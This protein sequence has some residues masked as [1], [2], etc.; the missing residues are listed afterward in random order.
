MARLTALF[1]MDGKAASSLKYLPE[2]S[3]L[4]PGYVKSWESLRSKT[5]LTLPP[6]T[7]MLRVPFPQC[8]KR[9]LMLRGFQGQLKWSQG[10][11]HGICTG[12]CSK[13][14]LHG[15]VKTQIPSTHSFTL[16][17][18][19]LLRNSATSCFAF[20][21]PIKA[22]S[23]LLVCAAFLGTDGTPEGENEEA[24][25]NVLRLVVSRYQEEIMFFNV[26]NAKQKKAILCYFP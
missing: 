21:P 9:L 7:K 11:S 18:L 3:I 25:C 5:Y 13:E 4:S 8:I 16:P 14:C 22:C 2:S 20:W 6:P 1:L 12:F 23:H 19:P 10:C 24:Q 26:Q 17:L 15:K